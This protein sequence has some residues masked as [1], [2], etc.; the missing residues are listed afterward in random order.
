MTAQNRVEMVYVNSQQPV[1]PKVGGFAIYT[2]FALVSLAE[3]LS[4]RDAC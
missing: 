3:I 2:R 4:D 1:Q